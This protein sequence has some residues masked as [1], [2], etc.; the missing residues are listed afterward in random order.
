MKMK[1]PGK[2]AVLTETC[3]GEDGVRACVARA[4]GALDQLNFTVTMIG[5]GTPKSAIETPTLGPGG[6]DKAVPMF[7]VV[8]TGLHRH[9]EHLRAKMQEA[10][11][12]GTGEEEPE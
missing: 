12:R 6:N 11:E 8:A 9:P 3:F 10:K 1:Q 4:Y 5:L 2:R 7:L